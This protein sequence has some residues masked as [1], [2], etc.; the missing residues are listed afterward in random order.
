MKTGK[1]KKEKN[2]S[3]RRKATSNVVNVN[4]GTLIVKLHVNGPAFNF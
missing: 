2:K 4:P 3:N 1:E